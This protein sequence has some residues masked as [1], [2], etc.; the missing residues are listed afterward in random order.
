MEGSDDG[1]ASPSAA[2]GRVGLYGKRAAVPTHV[3]ARP[4][5]DELVLLSLESEEYFGLDAV[6]A[7]MWQLLSSEPTVH[8]AFEAL[9]A[10]YDVDPETLAVDLERLLADL[11]SRKLIELVDRQAAEGSR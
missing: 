3:L 1:A 8:H 9:L 7:R 2:I 4:V 10:E 6:G 5:A 11:S